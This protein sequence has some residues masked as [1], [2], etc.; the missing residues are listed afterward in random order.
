MK[1]E[2]EG[3]HTRAEHLT[4]Q[5]SPADLLYL[6]KINE[7]GSREASTALVDRFLDEHAA[8]RLKPGTFTDVERYL[9]RHWAPLLG[10]PARKVTRADV[11][12]QLAKL[13]DKSGGYAANRAR[14][15]LSALFSCRLVRG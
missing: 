3:V 11:A 9:R 15:A 4:I 14:A 8:K 12:A 13:V 6:R 7:L 2:I 5:R 1:H 10:L